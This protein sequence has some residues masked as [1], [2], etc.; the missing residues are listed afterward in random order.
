MLGRIA[1]RTLKS[2]SKRKRSLHGDRRGKLGVGGAA[3]VV[4][5][6]LG[7]PLLVGSCPSPEPI[8]LLATQKVKE[9]QG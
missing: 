2:F 1:I 3:E 4:E 8:S 9:K 5:K 6:R 7:R